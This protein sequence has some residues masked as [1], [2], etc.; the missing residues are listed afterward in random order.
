M[1]KNIASF[2][3]FTNVL[4]RGEKNQVMLTSCN[5]ELKCFLRTAKIEV[6][7]ASMNSDNLSII[8]VCVQAGW[9]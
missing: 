7:I 9:H 3:F 5:V 4:W 1:N 8:T 2:C 6:R